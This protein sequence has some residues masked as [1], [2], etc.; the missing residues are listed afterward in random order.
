MGM[1]FQIIDDILDYTGDQNKIGKP[2][3]GDLRQG[4]ITLPM[5]F[6]MNNNPTDP[7]VIK[8]NDGKCISD[9]DELDRIIKLVS[10]S[11]AIDQSLDE[12]NRFILDAKNSLKTFE[13][14]HEKVLLEALTTYIIERKL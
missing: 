13:D 4:L 2:V 5:L 10:S 6:F 9:D 1:A 3:G 8:L 14:C 7:A 12:A 11:S